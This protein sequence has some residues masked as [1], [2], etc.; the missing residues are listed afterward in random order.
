[1]IV[2]RS[3]ILAAEQLG[4]REPRFGKQFGLPP[5]QGESKRLANQPK[6]LRSLQSGRCKGQQV[7]RQAE[8]QKT[9]YM[10]GFSPRTICNTISF[11]QKSSQGAERTR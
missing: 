9:E 1:M 3:R 5:Q 6:L 10:F 4:P 7:L 2:G 8:H 11:K